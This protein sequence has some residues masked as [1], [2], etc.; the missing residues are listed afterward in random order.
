[1]RDW[2]LWTLRGPALVYWLVID[3]F[4]VSAAVLLT[5]LGH[6]PRTED[7][8]R[9]IV[10]VLTA[11][12]VVIGTSVVGALRVEP[13]RS[14]WA[15]HVSYL[16]AG[17]FAL[18][19]NLLVVLMLGPALHGALSPRHRPHHWFFTTSATVL[20]T[21]A[22]RTVI[23]WSEPRTDLFAMVAAGA[24]LLVVRAL[25]VAIGLRLRNPAA[26][27][28]QVVGQMLDVT[29]GVV[30][31]CLGGL[32]AMAMTDDPLRV[33]LAAPPLLLLESAAQLP[34]WQRSAQ[35]DAKTGL[36]NSMHWDRLA[37]D[38]LDRARNR[39]SAAALLLLDLDHFKRVNDRVGH[40]AGDAAL[41][42]VGRLLLGS[43]RHG[44]LVGRFGGEEFVVLLPDTTPGE[45]EQTAQRVR[46]G[47]A[48]LRVPTTATDGRDHELSG[49][50]V[51][52][53]VATSPR[54]GYVLPDLMVAADSALLAAKSSGRNLVTVA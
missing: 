35:R 32:M 9:F 38:A 53:G 16:L 6:A 36:A 15:V 37:R 52:I 21:M 12:L 34:Q 10:L 46:A 23:G 31:V 18:P 50:T 5:V 24:T 20:A 17:V 22:A 2:P 4:A 48:Q 8:P 19:G 39:K 51:S 41:A 27:P 1:M 40:L 33:L 42:A 43:V 7:L 26:R 54:Y 44:E 25:I 30:A 3:G 49:L 14:P 29:V 28:E 13:Q 45:A 47:V 11:A